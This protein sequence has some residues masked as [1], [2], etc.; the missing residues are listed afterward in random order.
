MGNPPILIFDEATSALDS[1]AE[2][3]VQKAIEQATKN[4]TVIVIAHRLSTILSSDKIVVMDNGKIIEIG[5]H[6]ELLKTCEKYKKLH[7][8]QFKEK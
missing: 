7:E 1:E 3:K 6:T 8:M 2:H 5:K 4:R